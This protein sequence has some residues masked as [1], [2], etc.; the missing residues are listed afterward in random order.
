MPAIASIAAWKASSFALDGLLKPVIFLTNWS[1]AARTSSGVTGGSKLKSVLIFRHI[2]EDLHAGQGR[3][4][5]TAF[6]LLS[7]RIEGNGCNCQGCH[8]LLVSDFV[9]DLNLRDIACPFDLSLSQLYRERR[10]GEICFST[11][12]DSMGREAD[13]STPLRSGRN[14]TLNKE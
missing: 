13:S 5:V 8:R 1:E 3:R 2:F 7:D 12:V 10:S 6:T 14:D 4:R 9:V 11:E